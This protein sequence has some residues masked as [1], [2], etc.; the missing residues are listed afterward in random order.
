[1]LL[2]KCASFSKTETKLGLNIYVNQQ[3]Y[4]S[5]VCRCETV[6]VF[7]RLASTKVYTPGGGIKDRF[8]NSGVSTAVDMVTDQS[9]TVYTTVYQAV[10]EAGVR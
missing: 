2:I 3:Q 1:M 5:R 4:H 6:V 7:G 9:R 8:N 10:P